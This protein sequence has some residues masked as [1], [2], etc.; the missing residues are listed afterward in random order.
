MS[1]ESQGSILDPVLFSIFI[2]DLYNGVECILSQFTDD[3][4]LKRVADAPESCAIILRGLEVLEAV[5][6]IQ[7]R[8]VQ[9]PASG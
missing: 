6:E 1:G 2:N 3:S 4:E 9:S 5:S 8:E 7:Q